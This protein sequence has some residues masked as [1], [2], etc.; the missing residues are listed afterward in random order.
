MSAH[1][2][3]TKPLGKWKANKWAMQAS[4]SGKTPWKS[5]MD[6]GEVKPGGQRAGQEGGGGES[7]G[8]LLAWEATTADL[9]GQPDRHGNSFSPRRRI[10]RCRDGLKRDS[11]PTGAGKVLLKAEDRPR[12][13]HQR[14][15]DGVTEVIVG[16]EWSGRLSRR[17]QASQGCERGEEVQLT[18]AGSRPG[19]SRR[20][21]TCCRCA[22]KCARS[23]VRD[24]SSFRAISL[25]VSR[26]CA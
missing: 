6:F 1:V 8:D 22:R 4:S 18:E 24:T 13:L 3:Q 20:S 21:S 19:V 5:G 12:E 7:Q 2:E 10:R 17:P 11:G 25:I 26:F 15:A 14:R 23:E 16:S 9:V